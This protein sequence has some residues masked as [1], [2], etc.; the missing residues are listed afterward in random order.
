MTFTNTQKGMMAPQDIQGA[1]KT[2]A[3]GGLA[4]FPTDTIWTVGCDLSDPAACTSL[5]R[6][7][8]Q[9][10]PYGFEVLVNSL[11]MLKK[12]VPSL[13][14]KLE[15]LL[16]Y[17]NRP[18]S[19]LIP[20]PH[21]FP[22]HVFDQDPTFAVRLVRDEFSAQL[23][24]ETG[25]PLFSTFATTNDDLIPSTFGHISS[26]V[27]ER[28]DYVAKHRQSDKNKGRPAVVVALSENDEMVFLQE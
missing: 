21:L 6:L 18:L 2:I 27:L 24:Y 1:A 9:P 15:T 23:I 10:S 7:K 25:K 8:H 19:I 26:S 17:H 12:Y 16:F 28:M 5:L 22:K 11:G 20:P 13:H 4:L 14:P 3:S